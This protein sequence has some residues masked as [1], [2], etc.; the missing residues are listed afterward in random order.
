MAPTSAIRL[1]SANEILCYHKK[2]Y[3]GQLVSRLIA[4]LTSFDMIFDLSLSQVQVGYE[5][6]E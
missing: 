4:I 3:N 1:G 5:V 6:L 2:V